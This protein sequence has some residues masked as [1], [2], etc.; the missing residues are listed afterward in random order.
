MHWEAF[1]L[2]REVVE[3]LLLKLKEGL[4]FKGLA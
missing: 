3:D 2:T 4:K 1:S